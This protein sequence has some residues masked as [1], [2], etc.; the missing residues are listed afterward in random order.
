MHVHD[1]QSPHG[2]CDDGRPVV[3]AE[4]HAV[5]LLPL[6]ER[7]D[8]LIIWLAGL[9]EDT[10][11][12]YKTEKSALDEKVAEGKDLPAHEPREEW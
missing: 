10:V 2:L 9:Y 3:A 11:I 5:R 7:D 12:I 4:P 8:E 6:L 1:D